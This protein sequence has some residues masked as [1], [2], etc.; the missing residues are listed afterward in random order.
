[1]SI[2]YHC[3]LVLYERNKL[4]YCIS[5]SFVTK[6]GLLKSKLQEHG[7]RHIYINFQLSHEDYLP[8]W[9]QLTVLSCR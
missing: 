2:K 1:M 3:I 8:E 9:L 5:N 7:K 6:L 4:C